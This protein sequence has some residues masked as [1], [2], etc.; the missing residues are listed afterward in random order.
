MTERVRIVKMYSEPKLREMLEVQRWA[1]DGWVPMR[2][3]ECEKYGDACEFAMDASMTKKRVT[4]VVVFEEGKEV[5]SNFCTFTD[6]RVN[7]ESV[8]S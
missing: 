7:S 1:K 5:G 3:F 4:E 6:P 8:P 2:Q